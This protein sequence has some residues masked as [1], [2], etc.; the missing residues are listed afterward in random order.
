MSAEKAWSLLDFRPVVKYVPNCDDYIVYWNGI[1][2]PHKMALCIAS[3]LFGVYPTPEMKIVLQENY[4]KL[5]YANAFDSL[6]KWDSLVANRQMYG[7]LDNYMA[8]HITQLHEQKIPGAEVLGWFDYS[9][10]TIVSD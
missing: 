5:Y 3:Q 6:G 8:Q 9:R 7:I 1:V 2:M 10:A 4:L